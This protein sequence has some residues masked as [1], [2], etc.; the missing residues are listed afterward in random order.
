MS[1]QEREP[2]TDGQQSGGPLVVSFAALDRA[3]AY[4]ASNRIDHSA[5]RLAVVVQQMVDATIA[6]VLFTANPLTGKRHQA[7]I[8]ASPGLGEAV[9]SG[10]VTP[11][12]FV[13]DTASGAIRER[14]LGD[15]RLAVQAT[16]GGGTQRVEHEDQ[17][18]VACLSDTQLRDLARLGAQVELHYRMPMD[19]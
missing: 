10:T 17:S 15:K 11:D 8:D 1:I 3:V 7:V 18:S 2:Q 19:T 9:V 6:G 12:H 14:R 5:V 13:V 4:R 16:P